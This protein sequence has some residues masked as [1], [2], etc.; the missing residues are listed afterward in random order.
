MA[1]GLS[2]PEA[3][4]LDALDEEALIRCAHHYVPR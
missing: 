3:Q 1:S 4:V 2:A